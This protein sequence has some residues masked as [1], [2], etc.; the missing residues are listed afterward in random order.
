M[1][2]GT[3]L[4]PMTPVSWIALQVV[5]SLCYTLYVLLLWSLIADAVDYH[6]YITGQRNDGTVYATI[7]FIVF[8]AGSVSTSIIALLLELVGYDATLG[9]MNQLAGVPERI[10][11][12]VGFWPA[13]GA[14]LLFVCF[15][16]IYN[17]SDE[18][19]VRISDSLRKKS[20]E[21]EKKILGENE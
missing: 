18:E 5:A 15:K 1:Y 12:L 16:F 4:L 8:F 20:E 21:A 2:L 13:L 14:F 3:M 19:M 9:S 10:K 7:T 6:A 17:V 11:M